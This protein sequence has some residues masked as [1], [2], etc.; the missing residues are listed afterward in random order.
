M[1]KIVVAIVMAVSL[2]SP[3]YAGVLDDIT[4]NVKLPAGLTGGVGSAGGIDD[5]TAASGIKEAL[6]ISTANAVSSVSRLDG[7]FSNQAIK[8]LLP[9]KIRQAAEMLRKIGYEKQVDD[10]VLSMNRAA[11]TAAPKAKPHFIEAIKVMTF[12][13]ARKIL[14]GGNTAA[15]E[16]FKS[17]MSDKLYGEFKPI[18]G[19]SMEQV[20]VTRSYKEMAAEFTALPFVKPES[21]DLDHYVTTKALDGLFYVVGQEEQKI[22][23]DPAARVTDLLKTVFGK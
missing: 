5:R 22:R 8:I 17:K 11:E 2:I 14:S 1:K 21:I 20:G 12:D 18:I 10:F 7:Y 13:D 6:S 15:T 4:K 19:K 16:Y 23:A 9:D 3:V